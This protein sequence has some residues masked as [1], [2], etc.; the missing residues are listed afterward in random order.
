MSARRIAAL[1]AVLALAAAAPAQAQFRLDLNRLVDTAKN[2][3]KATGEIAEKEEIEIGSDMAARLLGAAPLAADEALQRYVNQVGRWLASQTERPDLPWKFGVLEAPQL[4]AFAT[5]GGNIFV[6]RGLVAQM[7]NE[8]ELAGVLAHEI[9]HVL[10]KHHLKA[11]QKTAQV[12][13]ANTAVTTFARQDRNTPARE[14]LLAAGSEL[15]SRGLDKSD[16]LEADR[17]GVVIAARGGYDAYGLPAVLQTLQAMNPEDSGLA[18]MFKTHPAPAERL[19]AL[20]KM[21]PTL[22]AYAAQKQLAA[23]FAGTARR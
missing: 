12:E 5:P 14:K 16:E 18:L 15:Y 20:E 7:N 11:I 4:N 22:D 8:A 21:Q 13:L 3:G 6:T 2:I 23:R 1:L 19:E 9:V 17:L 10:K